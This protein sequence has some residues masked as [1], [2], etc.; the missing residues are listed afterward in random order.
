LRKSAGRLAKLAGLTGH[1][2]AAGSRWAVAVDVA[3]RGAK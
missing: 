2:A 1:G 3:G